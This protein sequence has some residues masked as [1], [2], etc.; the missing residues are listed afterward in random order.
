MG[1]IAAL[2]ATIVLAAATLG[3]TAVLPTASAATC[4]PRV[5]QERPALNPDVPNGVIYTAHYNTCGESMTLSFKSRVFH[6]G[7][8]E[9]FARYFN[10]IGKDV[11]TVGTSGCGG[12]VV[13]G[14]YLTTLKIGQ[15][16]MAK[17]E[18]LTFT[19]P[20]SPCG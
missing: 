7:R 17:S 19:P 13:K 16:L 14:Q 6:E 20:N 5:W 3:S 1:K 8:Y 15:T 9:W 11:T 10:L 18:P 12:E 2:G 4:T